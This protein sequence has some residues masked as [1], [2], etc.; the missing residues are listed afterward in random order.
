MGTSRGTPLE[1][2]PFPNSISFSANPHA[3]WA[4]ISWFLSLGLNVAGIWAILRWRRYNDL[5]SQSAEPQHARVRIYLSP[6]IGHRDMEPVVDAIWVLL[7]ASVSLF[8]I[9][10]IHFLFLINRTVACIVLGCIVPLALAYIAVT[11]LLHFL[12]NSQYFTPF[13]PPS[14]ESSE[15]TQL[16]HQSTRSPSPIHCP[17]PGYLGEKSLRDDHEYRDHEVTAAGT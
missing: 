11:L 1:S 14:T 17:P 10:L 8:F 7:H 12:P 5:L 9:G 16:D 13:T 15:V 3:V 2:P 4:S 6:S